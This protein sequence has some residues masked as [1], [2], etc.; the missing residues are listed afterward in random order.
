MIASLVTALLTWTMLLPRRFIGSRTA[1][2]FKVWWDK[3]Y[4]EAGMRWHEEIERHCEASRVVLPLLTP[5]WRESEWTR[6]ET[7]GAEH[8]LLSCYW[9]RIIALIRKLLE[10]TSG[11]GAGRSP[12]PGR[13]TALFVHDAE[14]FWRCYRQIF[15]VDCP[16]ASPR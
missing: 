4:L 15:W 7:Y 6:Y 14:A 10:V 13:S 11:P 2:G 9:I 16:W 3:V 5:E 8:I 12:I 1:A